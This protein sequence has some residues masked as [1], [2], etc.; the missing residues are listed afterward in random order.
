MCQNWVF[1]TFSYK[2]VINNIEKTFT[3]VRVNIL[4]FLCI[5]LDVGHF[6]LEFSALIWYLPQENIDTYRRE[7]LFNVITDK[8]ILKSHESKH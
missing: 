6:V 3:S 8:S 4:T 7:S 1:W 2:P 5:V